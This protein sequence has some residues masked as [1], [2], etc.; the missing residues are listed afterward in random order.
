M[1]LIFALATPSPSSSKISS[2]PDRVT[3]APVLN[4][5]PTCV[6]LTTP[7][8]CWVAKG[9]ASNSISTASFKVAVTI[10]EEVYPVIVNSAPW[11]RITI[12]T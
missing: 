9:S 2:A 3:D 7:E 12:P 5:C 11:Y 4:P 10:V 1:P 6:T 8:P